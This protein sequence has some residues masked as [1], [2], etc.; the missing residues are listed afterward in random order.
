[1]V[2]NGKPCCERI[3]EF[4]CQDD[5]EGDCIGF[6]LNKC[7][8]W[9]KWTVVCACAEWLSGLC[10]C[11][12]NGMNNCLIYI[13]VNFLSQINLHN[14]YKCVLF[15]SYISLLYL[16]WILTHSLHIDKLMIGWFF[17]AIFQYNY[18]DSWD[19]HGMRPIILGYFFQ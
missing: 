19:K 11:R 10:I 3:S 5:P 8:E 18:G 9:M 6:Q 4:C 12:M 14:I 2:C 16:P 7:G 13:F 1:M 17:G 15:V